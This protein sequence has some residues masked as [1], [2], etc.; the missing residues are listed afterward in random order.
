QKAAYSFAIERGLDVVILL[1]ADG[2]YAPEV[3]PD[4]IDT[5]ERTNCDAVF[6][7]R[8]MKR[9]AARNGGMPLYKFLGNKALSRFEN[10]VLGSALT[11]FHSGYR[12]YRVDALKRVPFM[13]NSD[14]FDFD[15]QIIAQL[16]GVGARIVEIPIPTYYGDE[17]CYVNG[18]RYA[19]DVVRDVVE[20]RLASRGLG[21][22]A[23]VP[24]PKYGFKEEEGSSHKVVLDMM[25]TAPRSRLLDLGCAGGLLAE[26]LRKAG[27]YV[28]GVDYQQ[29]GQVHGHVDRFVE[30]DLAKGLPEALLGE[31][32]DI[33][34]A[35]DVIEHLPEPQDLLRQITA[36]LQPGGQVIISVPNFSHWYPRLRVALGLFGYDRL[37]IL[38][39]SHLR[40]FTRRSLARL[41]REAGFDVVE[42]RT[43][44]VPFT[45][46]M[47]ASSIVSLAQKVGGWLAATWPSLFAYQYI[48]RLTPH[49]SE[50]VYVSNGHV[51][52]PMPSTSLTSTP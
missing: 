45:A 5:F 8:M 14:G 34:I 15:T 7:S 52:A 40:F 4:F 11:E 29:V 38:D 27:H 30:A 3:L 9:G 37:G 10:W 23:W 2:Q 46:L 50:T 18:L 43:T 42:Q 31:S 17:I 6:G 25:G 19:W 41:V 12:A 48:W 44:S 20:Y 22:P 36:V 32:F 28:V 1:H 13:A 47:G 35:A 49:R 33:V 51:T 16:L 39:Q 21:T 24:R 26:R